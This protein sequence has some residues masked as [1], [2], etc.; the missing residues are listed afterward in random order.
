MHWQTPKH[1]VAHFQLNAED[2][3]LDA[4]RKALKFR[5]ADL[6]PDS[7]G[8][9]T[10]D[11]VW[12][13]LMSAKDFLDDF[14]DD[15]RALIPV[16]QIPAL[17]QALNS[18]V[19]RSDVSPAERVRTSTR[20]DIRGRVLLPRIGSGVFAAICAFL[21]TFSDKVKDHPVLG[22]WI[23]TSQG[24]MILLAALLYSA[25]FFVV[26][27]ISER[28]QE[29]RVEWLMTE[30]GVEESLTRLLRY[31]PS[32]ELHRSTFTSRELIALHEHDTARRHSID[33]RGDNFSRRILELYIRVFSML[34]FLPS[35]RLPAA[36]AEKVTK[37]QIDLLVQ[38]DLIRELPRNG[39]SRVYE[40]SNDVRKT[41]Q[42]DHS[43]S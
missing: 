41:F 26:T 19:Q 37:G 23:S 39:F 4:I 1:I 31:S 6:H 38:Q 43:H 35:R 20:E 25:L 18:A 34:L 22:P 32:G 29:T 33:W 27:W 13:Q 5:M 40:V 9:E 24:Q 10:D 8:G 42:K 7:N 12:D 3:S 30:E 11:D 2:D 21:F 17:I 16:S 36:I 28:A 14:Q 15:S